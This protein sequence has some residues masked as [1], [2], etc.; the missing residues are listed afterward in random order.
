MCMP[1]AGQGENELFGYGDGEG[2]HFDE[3]LAGILETLGLEEASEY[4][5]DLEKTD[6]A[7]NTVDTRLDMYTPLY[8]LL[9]SSEGYETSEVAD[10]WRIRTGIAQGDTALTTEVDLDLALENYEGMEDVDFETVWGAGHT[11]AERS[12]DSTEN[13]IEWVNA[14]ME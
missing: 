11:M 6:E 14:C 13:F 3:T 5:E 8:Y 2:A 9:S 7:G 12:G 4:V 1:D 10:Y